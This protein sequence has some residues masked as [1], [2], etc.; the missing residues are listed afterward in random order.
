[1]FGVRCSMFS[2]CSFCFI[3]LLSNNCQPL[4]RWTLSVSPHEA[5]LSRRA[6][7]LPKEVTRFALAEP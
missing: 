2:V 1:M 3:L 6:E 7:A 4:R 5:E